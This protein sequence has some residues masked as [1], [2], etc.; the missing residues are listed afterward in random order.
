MIDQLADVQPLPQ[1]PRRCRALVMQGGGALG[2]FGWGV[3]RELWRR[4]DYDP[5]IITGVSIGAINAAALAGGRLGPV[6]TLDALWARF[7]IDAPHLPAPLGDAVARAASAFGTPG[8]YRPRSD[9]FNIA[10]W[11]SVY[12]TT[13][14][15]RTLLDLIDFD[16]INAEADRRFVGVTA[17]CIETGEIRVFSNRSPGGFQV[18][19]V[20]ASGSLPPGFPATA[21]DDLSYWDGG[22]F[23][24][25]PLSPAIDA[26]P[27]DGDVET[28]I[29]V[30][31]LFPNRGETP[32]NLSGVVDRMVEMIFAN[33]L[34]FD[35]QTM[36]S[37]NQ[38]VEA[39]R[40][41][42]Q[43]LPPD[44][45]VRLMPGFR[46]LQQFKAIDRVRMITNEQ[47]ETVSAPSDFSAAGILARR[48]AGEAAARRVL[49]ESPAL[50]TASAAAPEAGPELAVWSGGR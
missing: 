45:P 36:R 5:Q 3:A 25:T 7:M 30:V 40:A 8:F 39:V 50:D 46:R 20:L 6:A 34:V 23:S 21:I 28:E 15:R 27:A 43:A 41:I 13:P 18:D 10:G 38:Y 49:A 31:N 11:T 48:A 29:T 35:L 24:N 4:T 17:V 16:R 1:A 19:H 12:D 44:S 22:L 47:G 14:L 32:R 9:L 26:L 2:A 33:R 37:I 42:D